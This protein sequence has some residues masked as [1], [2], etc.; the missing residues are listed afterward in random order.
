M[1]PPIVVGVC[2]VLET[3]FTH[4]GEVDYESFD[5][6]I[7]Y[8]ID[9]GVRSLMFPGFASEY[10]KLS[11]DERLQLTRRLLAITGSLSDFTT[12]ISVPDHATHIA[13]KRAVAAVQAGASAINILPPH[14]ESPSAAAVVA[15]IT[16]IANAVAPVPVIVQYAPA[17]TGT[18][19]DAAAIGRIAEHCI[20]I[21]QVKVES[22]P[23][24]TLIT[25]LAGQEPGLSSLVGYGGVQLIDALR[26]GAVGV[27]PGCSFPEVYMLMWELWGRGDFE[28]AVNLH[29]RLLPYI[30]YWMQGVELIIAAEKQI[31]ALR[32]L[33]AT[34]F[35]RTPARQLDSEERMTIDRFMNEFEKELSP[36]VMGE[37]P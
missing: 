31:S 35:C 6:L 8:Q 9:I 25:A 33:I 16:A 5:A 36:V 4:N 13:V 10:Y 14:Q 29:R 15:H 19:L 21:V 28:A 23:P 18:A 7:R 1:R 26:R 2:P 32:G 3:P 20:N 30:S 12:V 37:R 27:Q 17:Q 34:E 22:T 11:D 24:G